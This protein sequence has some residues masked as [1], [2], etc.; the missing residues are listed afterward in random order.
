MT[1]VISPFGGSANRSA[2]SAAVPRRS[3]ERFVNSRRHLAQLV[4]SRIRSCERAQRRRQALRAA[5]RRPP[6]NPTERARPTTQ[7]EPSRRAARTRRNWYRSA[8]RPDVT[9]AV[10]TADAPG[11]ALRHL[12]AG[13]ERSTHEPRAGIR[14]TGHAGIGDERDAVARLQAREKL[15]RTRRLVVRVVDRSRASIVCRCSKPRVCRVSSHSTTSAM[16]NSASTRN[17]MS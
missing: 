6:A 3:P 5:P 9:S 14:D 1:S 7:T 8:T 11:R 13:F 4:R 17:V 2:S 12:H 16:R 10:S 15:C